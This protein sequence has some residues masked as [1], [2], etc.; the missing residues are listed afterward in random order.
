[1]RKWLLAAAFSAAAW[2]A[3]A[4][5]RVPVSDDT[6]VES[7]PVVAGWSSVQRE[8]RRQLT[9]KQS[10]PAA[11]VKAAN[12]YLD[13]ARDQ[14]DARYAGYAMGALQAWQDVPESQT[15]A[16]VLVMRATV[17]QFLHDFERAESNLRA[18]LAR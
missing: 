8:M 16:Q 13:L 18:A 5:P 11:A 14:G 4:D 6:V 2:I 1:M 12:S 17:A 3:H 7:L 10:D 15:P 9:Q